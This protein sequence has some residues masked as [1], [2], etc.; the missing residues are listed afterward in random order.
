MAKFT[1]ER[2]HEM[3]SCPGDNQMLSIIRILKKIPIL[4]HLNTDGM[5]FSPRG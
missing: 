2:D 3:V 5:F 4:I 1:L